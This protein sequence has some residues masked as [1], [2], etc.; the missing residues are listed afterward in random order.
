[1]KSV[2]VRRFYGPYFPAFG[3]NTGRYGVSLRIQFECEK[4]RTRK[5]PNTDT[6][7]AVKVAANKSNNKCK[8]K[9]IFKH[10]IL[11]KPLTCKSKTISHIIHSFDYLSRFYFMGIQIS[12]KKENHP[13]FLNCHK[14]KTN[15]KQGKPLALSLC[16]CNAKCQLLP[17]RYWH[18]T[19]FS[20]IY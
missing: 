8:F 11:F 3:L 13:I 9:I 20:R 14:L 6:S 15:N 12:V 4:I 1:M 10:K 7:Y 19:L 5:T 2:H 18:D 17:V 16:D